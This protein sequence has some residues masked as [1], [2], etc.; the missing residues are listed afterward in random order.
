MSIILMQRRSLLFEKKEGVSTITYLYF[1]KY[2]DWSGKI[3]IVVYS[4]YGR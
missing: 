2:E 3:I 1:E 4:V